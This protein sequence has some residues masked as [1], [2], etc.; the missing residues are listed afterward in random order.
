MA[1][2]HLFP[3][4]ILTSNVLGQNSSLKT[5]QSIARG[6]LENIEIQRR[7]RRRIVDKRL[8][9]MYERAKEK[10]VVD[11]IVKKTR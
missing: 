6:E 7:Q 2:S 1:G 10:K 8:H 9:T 5:A 11:V 4:V 3:S